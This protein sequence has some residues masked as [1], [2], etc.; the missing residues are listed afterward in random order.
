MENQIEIVRG[1]DVY[2]PKGN[3]NGNYYEPLWVAEWTNVSGKICREHGR[4]PE[5]AMLR[6]RERVKNNA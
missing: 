6:A 1:N 2:F 4:T 3:E 5:E